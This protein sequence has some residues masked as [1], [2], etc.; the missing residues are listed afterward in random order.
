ML[1]LSSDKRLQWLAE[2]KRRTERREAFCV[3]RLCRA[4]L[5]A[6]DGAVSVY[7]SSVHEGAIQQTGK[8]MSEIKVWFLIEP[9]RR[10]KDL[11]NDSHFLC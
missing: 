1:L 11:Q 6:G 4:A 9:V 2:E 5:N 3:N 8:A 10:S 7:S